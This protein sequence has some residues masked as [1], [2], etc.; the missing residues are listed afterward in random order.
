[1]GWEMAEGGVAAA[2]G[3]DIMAGHRKQV[4]PYARTIVGGAYIGSNAIGL[5]KIDI[6][7]GSVYVGTME[8]TTAA[9]GLNKQ[10]DVLPQNINIPANTMLHAYITVAGA[11]N[12]TKF[13]FLT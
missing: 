3:V 4:V 7:V 10:V 8:V 9:A 12:V 1:M 6:F 2:V 5:G 13:W 11:A